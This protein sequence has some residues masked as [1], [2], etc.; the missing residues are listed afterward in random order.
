MPVQTIG[1]LAVE[2]MLIN[3]DTTAKKRVRAAL[4]R[5][6]LAIR[7]LAR[8]MAPRDEGFLE[9]AIEIR[10]E[11]TERAR[12]SGGRFTYKPIEVYIDMDVPIEGR[13]GKTVGNYAY[14]VHEHLHPVPGG[15]KLGDESERKQAENPGIQVGGLFLERAAEAQEKDLDAALLDI[16]RNL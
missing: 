11:S 7:D 5:R 9:K 6:A 15:W 10:G 1:L 12:D 16:V 4:V 3:V 8:K 14:F 13:D 2:T